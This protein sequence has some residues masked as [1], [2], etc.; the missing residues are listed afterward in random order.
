[1]NPRT[2]NNSEIQNVNPTSGPNDQGSL[3]EA[4]SL[5]ERRIQMT[6]TPVNRLV[7]KLAI[8]SMISMLVSSL[9]NLADAFFVG[10]ISTQATAAVGV[11]L[12]LM[13]IMQA[14]GF[15][16]GHGSGNF[17]SMKLGKREIEEA[18]T[19]AANGF[20]LSFSIG[21]AIMVLG[22]I[23][24]HPFARILGATPTIMKDTAAYMNIIL[25]GAPFFT[26]QLVINNQLRFEGSASYAMVGLVSGAVLNVILDPLLMFGAGMGVR[27]AALATIVSQFVSFVLLFIGSRKGPNIP[28]HL[29]N[30]RIS[31]YYF[32]QICKGGT[33]SLVRQGLNSAAVSVM[34]TIAGLLGGDPAIAAMAIVGRV[35]MISISLLIGFG[36]GMQPVCTF[37]Y[38]AGILARLKE[39]KRFCIKYGTIFMTCAG[40]LFSVF[41]PEVVKFF[42]NDPEVIAIGTRALR[43]LVIAFPLEAYIMVNNML[44]QAINKSGPATLL[45]S[46]RSGLCYIPFVL[47]LS[48][49]LGLTG[50]EM[51]Q[52]WA[53]IGTFLIAIPLTRKV[54]KDLDREDIL[55]SIQL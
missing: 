48:H 30:V 8:P 35:M 25:I 1:M 16:C 6:T 40:I 55:R 3:E 43:F 44:M 46:A 42:R 52:M 49:F 22:I 54:M 31:R 47:I 9:Y 12:P 20:A 51:S 11:V 7:V 53:D 41:A 27:G 33:P 10:Q 2:K 26:S 23:F 38:G 45:A 37:N 39:A 19:M 17:I 13:A 50:L 34:N 18:R 36:H 24:L 14:F 15:F 28:I 21:A 4:K 32:L 5:E 29:K